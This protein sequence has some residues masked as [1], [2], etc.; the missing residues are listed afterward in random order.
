MQPDD[1]ALLRE[2]A[3]DHSEQAFR[4]LVERHVNMVHAVALR[5]VANAQLAEDVTQAVF[6]VL[7]QKAA[8]IPQNT[9]LAGWLFRATRFAAANVKRAETRREHW[10]QKAAQMEPPSPSDPEQD[11]ITP[12][13]G[14]ALEELPERDRAAILLRF[15]ESKSIED[16]GRTLGT[17]EGAAKMRLSRA[18]EKLRLIFRKR[19]VVVTTAAMLGVLAAQ[20]AHAAQAGLASSVVAYALLNQT[21]A[22]TLPLVKGTLA[23]MAQTKSKTF[24]ITALVLLFGGGTAVVVQQSLQNKTAPSS[25][26][27]SKKPA[28]VA[29]NTNFPGKA[30]VFRNI[31]S[32]NRHPDFEDALT[33]MRATFDVKSSAEMAS[34]DLAPYRFVIIPG[35]QWRTDFYQQYAANADRFDRYVTNGGTLV[36]ELNGAERDGITL[37]RGVSM[38]PHGSLDNTILVPDH[39]ILTPLGGRPIHANSASHGY[40]DGVPKDALVL[41]TETTDGQADTNKP[42]FIEYKHG[43]GRVIAACQCFHDQDRSGRG[44]LMETLIDYASERKWFSPK[45]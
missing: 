40:L 6:I 5:Q 8:S 22:S 42:T 41:V 7:A 34:T 11:Q 13:L 43:A 10:E 28:A 44:P 45:K 2:Y 38:V 31:P 9:I 4:T 14:D 16:V 18:V 23:L 26:A 19:G 25:G 35:A 20:S 12:L 17:S 30:L 3:R 1:I 24:V 37:P 21:T 36:L 32:W 29:A 39:P 27:D 15:F 33:E